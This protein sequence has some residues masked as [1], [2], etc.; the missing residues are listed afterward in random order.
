LSPV[1]IY[2]GNKESKCE[3]YTILKFQVPF[4][5]D[6]FG[7]RWVTTSMWRQSSSESGVLKRLSHCL[8]LDSVEDYVYN[9]II[10]VAHNTKTKW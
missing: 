7:T 10:L 2:I 1:T 6:N 9:W 8:A 4:M 3:Q 5:M